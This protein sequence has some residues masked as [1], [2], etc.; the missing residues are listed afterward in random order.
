MPS[1]FLYLFSNDDGYE[2]KITPNRVNPSLMVSAQYGLTDVV[3]DVQ[4]VIYGR[5]EWAALRGMQIAY[6]RGNNDLTR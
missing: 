1:R 6:T 4:D 5:P 3:S 2:V